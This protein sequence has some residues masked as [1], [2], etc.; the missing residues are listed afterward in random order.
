MRWRTGSTSR[1]ARIELEAGARQGLTQ[2]TRY[3]T[4]FELLA[5]F[6]KETETE[7]EYELEPGPELKE[8]TSKSTDVTP[9]VEVEFNIPIFDTGKARLRK[10]ELAYMQGAN[11]LAQKAV[12]ARSRARAA[13]PAYR[14][15][16]DIAR[17]YRDA[18]LPL[19]TV[20]EQ[21][22]L[23]TY[24][25]MITNTFELLAGSSAQAGRHDHGRG[26][27]TTILARRCEPCRSDLWRG[28]GAGGTP[29]MAAAAQQ[30]IRTEH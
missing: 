8:E 4:D 16:H 20:I 19:R 12:E 10:G 18:V 21:E 23:L 25:G 29:V 9:Q 26:G 14:S 15:T 30:E 13:Y 22:E 2:A 11:R 1:L 3:V 24:N 6:E 17:H 7:T 27:E 28:G 5:G